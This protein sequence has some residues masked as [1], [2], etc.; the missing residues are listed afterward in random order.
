MRALR[1]VKVVRDVRRRV[2]RSGVRKV[3]MV[4][5]ETGR[6]VC[7]E[8]GGCPIPGLEEGRAGESRYHII[9]GP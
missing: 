5:R 4:P 9:E 3:P 6:V 2:R 8:D 7:G 1:R